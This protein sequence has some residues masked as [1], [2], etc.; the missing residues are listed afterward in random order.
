MQGQLTL[1]V[2]MPVIIPRAFMEAGY[3]ADAILANG[4]SVVVQLEG[5]STLK[6]VQC[7]VAKYMNDGFAQYRVNTSLKH[8]N[9][10]Y[11]GWG[12]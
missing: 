10:Q 12:E 9:S 3:D 2:G 6:P 1:K 4:V 11:A 8:V 7:N 5:S